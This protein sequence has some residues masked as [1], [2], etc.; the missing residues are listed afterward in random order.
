M[1]LKEVFFR[2]VED[3]RRDLVHVGIVVVGNQEGLGRSAERF[4]VRSQVG[5]FGYCNIKVR[6]VDDFLLES[7]L[8]GVDERLC[9][10]LDGSKA[11]VFF[12]GLVEMECKFNLGRPGN[13]FIPIFILFGLKTVNLIPFMV[14]LGQLEDV[15]GS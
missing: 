9:F 15:L 14:N 7:L 2:G 10:L 13:Q 4:R 5:G 11:R 8:E 12:G 6:S 1:V 3:V